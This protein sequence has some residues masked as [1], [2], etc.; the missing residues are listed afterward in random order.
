MVPGQRQPIRLQRE[1]TRTEGELL[2]KSRV[3]RVTS[4]MEWTSADA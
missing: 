4:S 1:G 3:L 2:S